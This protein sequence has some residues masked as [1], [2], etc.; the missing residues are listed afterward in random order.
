MA[1]ATKFPKNETDSDSESTSGSESDDVEEGM[2]NLLSKF[3]MVNVAVASDVP[4]WLGVDA[5][6]ITSKGGQ[7]YTLELPTGFGGFGVAVK[8]SEK[9]EHLIRRIPWKKANCH[10]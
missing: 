10:E 1:E 9:E 2:I 7:K 6:R 5:E 3:R 8:R 4:V